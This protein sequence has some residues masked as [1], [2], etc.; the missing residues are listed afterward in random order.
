MNFKYDTKYKYLKLKMNKQNYLQLKVT[1]HCTEKKSQQARRQP[2]NM[3]KI[4][5]N[6][7][8]LM[9]CYCCSS[10]SLMCDP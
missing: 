2:M 9:C 8:N 10:N 6:H 5:A 4:F 3:R 7:K 1:V